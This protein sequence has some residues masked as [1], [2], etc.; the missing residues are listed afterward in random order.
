[1]TRSTTDHAADIRQTLKARHGWTGRD[2]SVRA[3]YYSMG[4][5]LRISIKNPNIPRAIVCAIAKPSERIDRDQFG[6]ILG[7]GNRFVDIHY[8]SEALHIIGARFSLA[9]EAAVA[10]LPPKG[11]DSRSLINIEG[12]PYLVGRSTN[13]WGLSIWDSQSHCTECSE[14]S[15]T[16]Q[17]IGVAML[18]REVH[19]DIDVR[20]EF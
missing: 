2:V 16:A 8:A 10:Q 4:S 17:W 9:V 14:I 12:T 11:Q 19:V 6:E 1:M 18:N 13:Y 7:G 3:D 15:N 20:E 5:S